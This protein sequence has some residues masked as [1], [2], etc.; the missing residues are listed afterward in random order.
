MRRA[1]LSAP[2]RPPT[3]NE[4][5]EVL[6]EARSLSLWFPPATQLAFTVT[7]HPLVIPPTNRVEDGQAVVVLSNVN[8]GTDDCDEFVICHSDWQVLGWGETWTPR[9]WWTTVQRSVAWLSAPARGSLGVKEAQRVL[10]GVVS[11]SAELNED[12]RG[13]LSRQQIWR[14]TLRTCTTRRVMGAQEVMHHSFRHP[15]CIKTWSSSPPARSQLPSRSSGVLMDVFGVCKTLSWRI[16]ADAVQHLGT[17]GKNHSTAGR[18]CLSPTSRLPTESSGR[19]RLPGMAAVKTVS[20]DSAR[21]CPA[22]L[23]GQ[24][25]RTTPAKCS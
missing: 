18:R 15:A 3:P 14:W 11:A 2:H 21:P 7:V 10:T 17:A 25:T 6:P 20:F 4:V 5:R 22:H 1:I 13:R 9:P 19:A 8:V 16:P 23:W 12:D 24:G